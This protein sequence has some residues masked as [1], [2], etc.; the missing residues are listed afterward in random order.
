MQL[1]ATRAGG[2]PQDIELPAINQRVG[3]ADNAIETFSLVDA[4]F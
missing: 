1:R 2:A 3:M 4:G